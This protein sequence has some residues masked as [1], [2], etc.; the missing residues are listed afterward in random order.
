MS[1]GSADKVR[2]DPFVIEDRNELASFI[3]NSVHRLRSSL[4]VMRIYT[5]LIQS[6]VYG[7]IEGEMIDKIGSL[8]SAIDELSGY[9]DVIQDIGSIGTASLAPAEIDL[10]EMSVDVLKG[11]SSRQ[12]SRVRLKNP[13]FPGQVS[14]Y[15]DRD[16]AS[17]ILKNL[18]EYSL[19]NGMPE[20]EVHLNVDLES[21][22]PFIRVWSTADPLGDDESA[23]MVKALSSTTPPISIQSWRS[24]SLPIAQRL[25]SMAGWPMT[26]EEEGEGWA[27]T[28]R[29][30]SVLP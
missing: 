14:G 10:Y 21:E 25:C 28:V 1:E 9:M 16:I 27:Y 22:V 30:K 12:R 20:N 11:F 13:S 26:V 15:V 18:I 3:Q 7:Q 8:E 2:E 5:E 4:T 24:L 19:F 23:A 29:M 6:G 17:R